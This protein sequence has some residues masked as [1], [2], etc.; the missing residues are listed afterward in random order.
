[1]LLIKPLPV[2]GLSGFAI[3]IA[4]IGILMSLFML[5]IPVIYERYD[6]FAQLARTLKEV[7]VSF[8]LAGTGTAASLLTGL[9]FQYTQFLTRLI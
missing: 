4:L 5:V 2:A 3:F 6:K 8:I 1:M 7:R 9:V